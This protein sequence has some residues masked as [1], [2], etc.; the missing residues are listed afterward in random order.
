MQATAQHLEL[1]PPHM[2]R[3][4]GP[5]VWALL[6]HGL[7]L[8][9]LT[10]GVG[11][12][13]DTTVV[14][15]AELWSTL[16]QVAAPKL[17]TPEPSPPPPP[18]PVAEPKA[19]SAPPPP[20][21]APSEAQIALEKKREQLKLQEQKAQGEAKRKAAEK[22]A[23]QKEAERQK[24]EAAQAKAKE[25]E[26]AQKQKA[27][28]QAK[29]KAKEEAR[30]KQDAARQQAQLEAERRKNIERMMGQAGATGAA[31][32]TG[33]AQRSAGPS[34]TYAGKLVGRIKPNIVFPDTVPGNPRAE[35]EVRTLPDGS[36]VGRR[37]LKSSGHAAWDDAVLRAIDRTN[38]LPQ[39]EDGRVPSVIILGFRPL[40]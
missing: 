28:E 24:R 12:Q 2:G 32:A 37:L 34:A 15:E 27:Q 3:W 31:N 35:V 10:W 20:P 1:A 13:R 40:D 16:P 30:A 17:V 4:R 5:L 7:L 9:A 6:V 21:P 11:W 8:V 39:D 26:L 14:M 36:I 22:L 33:N 19:Q 18:A 25:Q 23:A 38:K 29:A